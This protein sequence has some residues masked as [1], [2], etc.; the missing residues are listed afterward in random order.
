MRTQLL[1]VSALVLMLSFGCAGHSSR[2]TN[3]DRVES[4]PNFP[5]GSVVY[6]NDMELDYSIERDPSDE[7]ILTGTLIPRG[8]A[9]GTPVEMAVI[10]FELIRDTTVT[11]SFS[12]P[13]AARNMRIPLTFQHRFKP[14]GGFDGIMFT[15]DIHLSE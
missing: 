15:W 9:A 13:V 5:C 4:C 8:V 11:E 14:Q 6:Y 10:S 7:F 1:F 12:F 3:R 2:H